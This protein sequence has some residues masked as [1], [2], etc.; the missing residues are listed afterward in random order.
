MLL[1]NRLPV[2][3]AVRRSHRGRSRMRRE[4]EP[5]SLTKAARVVFEDRPR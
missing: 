2:F 4:A 5:G 3:G 1:I